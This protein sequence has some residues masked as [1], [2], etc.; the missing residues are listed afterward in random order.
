MT[1]WTPEELGPIGRA[2]ELQLI[3]LRERGEISNASL[4]RLERDID[5]DEPRGDD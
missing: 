4:R 1:A 5:L 2:T 3:G